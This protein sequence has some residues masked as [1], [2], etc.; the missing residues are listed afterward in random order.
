MTL[1]E[2]LSKNGLGSP[3]VI[4]DGK[5]HRFKANNDKQKN[6]WYIGFN[7]GDFQA[8]SFGCWKRSINKTFCSIEKEL[9]TPKQKQEY[10]KKMNLISNEIQKLKREASLK[11]S[12]TQKTTKET[13]NNRFNNG[14]SEGVNNHPYLMKKQIWG[15][16][17]RLDGDKLLIPMFNIQGELCS[18]QTINHEGGKRFM[19]GGQ[20]NGLFNL[21][22]SPEKNL[23]LCEGY[24]TGSTI[25]QA[26]GQAIAICFSAGN[27]KEVAI[28][29]ANKHPNISLLIAGDNDQWG[30]SN[31]G[32]NKAQEIAQTVGAGVVFPEFKETDLKN[33]PTDF[34]DLHALSGLQEV[35]RQIEQSQF[36]G[37]KPETIRKPKES[38]VFYR[39]FYEAIEELENDKQKAEAYRIACEY[40]LNHRKIKSEFYGV[41]I[42]FRLIEPQLD[43]N[44]RKWINGQKGGRPTKSI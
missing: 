15:Y 9:F 16:S 26:T 44:Y 34:N 3:K 13:A 20:V 37:L 27:I 1:Q 21:I 8:G 32:K 36:Q 42:A 18:L 40:G 5:L 33:K 4:I 31:T 29:L 17:L 43:A 28:A 24:A 11:K 22:G 2:A 6:S 12:E 14:K 7:N 30:E 41:R 39:S 23:I 10:A 35:K 38:F 25:H 19:K